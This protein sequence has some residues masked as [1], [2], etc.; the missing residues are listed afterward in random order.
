MP[1]KLTTSE[2]IERARQVHGDRYDYARTVYVNN[3][4]KVI[5]TCPEHGDFEQR[6]NKHTKGQGC[7]SCGR[8]ATTAAQTLTTSEFIA[9][10][11][12]VHGDRYDYDRTVY[13]NSK[14]KIIITCTE[15]GDF[16]QLPTSHMRGIGCA[17]CAIAAKTLTAETFIE[18]ARAVH[19]DRYDYS[20]TEYVNNKRKLII[21]C[22]EHGD[23]EQEA[24]SHTRGQGCPSCGA[25]SRAA[26]KALTA[27][28]F[29]AKAREAHGDR[30]D[31]SKSV[32][33]SAHTKVII[34]CPEHGDFEQRPNDHTRGIGCQSCANH[35]YQPNKTGYLYFLLDTE[36]HSRIKIGISN[37]TKQRFQTLRRET[38]FAFEPMEII[39][40]Y[41]EIAPQLEKLCHDALPSANLSGFDGATEWMRF[42]GAVVRQLI[43]TCESYRLLDTTAHTR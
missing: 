41:G 7:T 5:I 38:P 34:T 11:R 3:K 40:T 32:Y 19:G 16:E 14:R 4:R 26:A 36:T 12:A 21:T 1:T 10:A 42:D 6:P 17:S 9:K 43:E 25:V 24:K 13:V 8:L 18:K 29:I 33:A 20:K 37:D 30:Y 31:Y 23:F 39:E 2:F 28:T 22:P 15:H 35:G 27:E